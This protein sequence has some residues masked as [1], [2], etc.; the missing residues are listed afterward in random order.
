[1]I[2]LHPS[3]DIVEQKPGIEGMYRQI[4]LC[5]RIS[6]KTEDKINETSYKKFIAMMDKLGHYATFEHGTIYMTLDNSKTSYGYESLLFK[7][8]SNPYTKVK[9]NDNNPGKAFVTT[10]YR[11][12]CENGWQDDLKYMCEPTEWHEKRYT[13]VF[14][15]DIGVSREFNRHR[16]DSILE[17]STRYCDYTKDKFS[18]EL[19]IMI[20]VWLEGMS[21]HIMD[22]LS[23]V[24]LLDFCKDLSVGMESD[25]TDID[26]WLFANMACEWCYETLVKKFSW[27]AQKAR[28]VLPLDT[29]TTLAH[30]AFKSDWK[31]FFDLRA[32]GTTGEPHPSA[33][34]LAEPLMKSFGENGYI[35]I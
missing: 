16:A 2:L 23:K 21:N 25:W 5:G 29:K 35:R 12:I 8:S 10:N 3:F 24:S 9:F 34:Q 19:R 20:P 17:E 31:H 26:C 1:M 22:K 30:T 18:N 15:C 27:T 7:Y 28:T 11:V 14:T 33:K 6:H 13:V 4:E 32:L